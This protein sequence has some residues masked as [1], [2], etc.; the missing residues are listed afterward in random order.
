MVTVELTLQTTTTQTRF[1]APFAKLAQSCC[2]PSFFHSFL[3]S[4]VL[5]SGLEA[6][7]DLPTHAAIMLP[8]QSRLVLSSAH[9][10]RFNLVLCNTDISRS[11]CL[12]LSRE[13]DLRLFQVKSD[14]FSLCLFFNLYLVHRRC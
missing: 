8:V 9:C 11:M 1:S 6:F 10:K 13:L 3:H 14:L 12:L 5:A 4:A 7:Q 2:Y